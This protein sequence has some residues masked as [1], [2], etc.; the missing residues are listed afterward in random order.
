MK[1]YFD[2]NEGANDHQNYE[3]II[4]NESDQIN[5]SNPRVQGHRV[6]NNDLYDEND[7][8]LLIHDSQQDI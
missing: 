7:N 8:N 4:M 5:R 6:N 1:I 3:N 2:E